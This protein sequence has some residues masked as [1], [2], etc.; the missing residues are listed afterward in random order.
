MAKDFLSDPDIRTIIDEISEVAGYLW[1]KGWAERNAGNISVNIPVPGSRFL[2]HGL[3]NTQEILLEKMYPALSDQF[4]VL[5]G[6]G[7]RMRDVAKEPLQNLCFIKINESGSAYYHVCQQQ[8][9]GTGYREQGT[10]RP[11]SELPTHL[12]IHEMLLKKDSAR[13]A[14]VH[15]HANELISLTQIPDFK[16]T[17]K[18]NDLLWR[19]HPETIIF[20]PQGIGFIPFTLPGTITIAEETAEALKDHPAVIWEKHGVISTGSSVLEAFD[21]IDILT[22]STRIFFNV[23]NA[24]YQ[25]EGL[26]EDQLNQIRYNYNL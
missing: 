12:A 20:V 14:V 6:T 21:T 9:T 18:I 24:G 8:K 23:R 5:T 2:E 13:K 1:D 3:N 15:T 26:S 11:T 19:M 10:G 22:K 25:P 4:F 7:T 16:S 17:E